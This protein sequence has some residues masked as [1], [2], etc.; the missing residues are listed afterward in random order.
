MIHQYK[1]NGYNIVLDVYSGAVHYV[2]EIAYDMIALYENTPK[3]SIFITPPWNFSFSLKAQ[4]PDFVS[5]KCIPVNERIFEWEKRMEV[6]NR[7]KFTKVGWGILQELRENYPKL[8][9][10]EL[11]KIKK[12]YGAEYFLAN[13]TI[14]LNLKVVHEN[15]SFRLYKL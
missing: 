15:K 6:L 11:I 4:R 8:T 13:S 1:L 3:D 2:D 14:H 7:G 10:Q 12:K 5:F 9:E